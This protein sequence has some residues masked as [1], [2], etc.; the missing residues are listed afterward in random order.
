LPFSAQL[1]QSVVMLP[2]PTTL[3]DHEEITRRW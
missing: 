2:I 3:A 1:P